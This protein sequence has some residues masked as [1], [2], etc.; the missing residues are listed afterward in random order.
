MAPQA[1]TPA[2]EAPHR[3]RAMAVGRGSW[4]QGHRA[5]P[6]GLPGALAQ[7]SVPAPALS[8]RRGRSPQLPTVA[9]SVD[10]RPAGDT[11]GLSRLLALTTRT[12][13]HLAVGPPTR[14]A[15]HT[16]AGLSGRRQRPAG[17]RGPPARRCSPAGAPDTPARG[18][19]WPALAG[20][21]SCGLCA[22]LVLLCWDTPTAAPRHHKV[23]LLLRPGPVV[24]TF[25]RTALGRC[26][27]VR[28]PE[29]GASP[30]SPE[31][32]GQ[33]YRL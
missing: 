20:P 21:T 23:G 2:P 3:G 6:A 29:G 12:H 11:L 32:L 5:P 27:Q 33:A 1:V 15:A 24:D 17:P 22:P 28:G 31:N 16:Q 13:S 18:H 7:H 26:A 19:R 8:L 25:T 10:T 14:M 30:G 4:G 9:H